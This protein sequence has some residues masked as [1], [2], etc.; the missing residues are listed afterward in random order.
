MLSQDLGA[1]IRVAGLPG[2]ELEVWSERLVLPWT[3]R[4]GGLVGSAVRFSDELYEVVTGAADGRGWRLRPWSEGEAVRGV[5]PLDATWVEALAEDEERHRGAAG[6]RLWTLPLSPLLALAPGRLQLRWQAEWGFPAHH[7][8]LISAVLELGA[9]AFLLIHLLAAAFGGDGT[10]AGIPPLLVL[11]AAPLWVEG[12]LRIF[13]VLGHGEPMG[14]LVGAPLLLVKPPN[15]Q[16]PEEGPVLHALDP[17]EGRLDLV[18][19][20][21][22]VDWHEDG[23]LRYRGEPYRLHASDRLGRDWIYSFRR[24]DGDGGLALKLGP[25]APPERRVPAAAPPHGPRVLEMALGTALAC[26]AP[27]DMQQRWA[28]M[29]G[30]RPL[31]FT[32]T[33]AVAELVGGAVNLRGAA[34]SSGPMLIM[35]LCFVAEGLV[36]LVLCAATGGPVGSLLGLALGPLLGRL[37]SRLPSGP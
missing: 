8:T 37:I 15:G 25:P 22:R 7:A 23:I 35:N 4:R 24:V 9:G 12:L 20:V 31:W 36:R 19:P 17:E 34:G 18:S 3:P 29:L 10:L 26:L 28:A 2:G 6:R 14:S 33:G 5:F 32:V 1:G 13:V 21:Q 11:L 30:T 27:G 16:T